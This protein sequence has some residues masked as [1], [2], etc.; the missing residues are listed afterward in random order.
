MDNK[1]LPVKTEN[2]KKVVFLAG[3]LLGALVFLLIF[4]FQVL[5]FTYTDWLLP[6][7]GGD[8]SQHYLG[9]VEYRASAWNFPIGLMDNVLYPEKV[10]VVYTDSIPLL[11]FFF[12]LISGILP[13]NFQYLGLFG[14]LCY[15]LQGGFAAI[16]IFHF[17]KQK[18]PSVIGSLLF[19]CSL[20]L[21]HRMFAHTALSAHF[22]ILASLYL[23]LC[24]EDQISTKRSVLSWTAQIGRAHV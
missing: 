22:L 7:D 14:L 9:W 17:T 24:R 20:L 11:A 4:G 5:D 3:A 1:Q 6:K 23:W 12:K 13:A 8:L 16:L 18:W 19:S 21:L 2:E 15:V 10:S